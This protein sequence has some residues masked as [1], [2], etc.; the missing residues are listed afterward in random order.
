MAIALLC[1]TAAAT[2][3]TVEPE[4][5]ASNGVPVTI[6]ADDAAQRY[7]YTAPAIM[8]SDNRGFF[9]VAAVDHGGAK[10]PVLV[11]GTLMYRGG[12]RFYDQAFLPDGEEL[13]G[14]FDGR[15]AFSCASAQG[16]MRSEN[17]Q[18]APTAAQIQKHAENG[19]LP[20]QLRAG[21]LNPVVIH[22]PVSY[23]D[24]VRE[25]LAAE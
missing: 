24:A 21:S 10:T 11:S 17:F 2:G 12:W 13:P 4:V 22:V 25:V 23:F 1:C 9:F 3:R 15:H 6:S 8:L 5:H 19:I 16:C 18:V 14:K 20:I 7:E